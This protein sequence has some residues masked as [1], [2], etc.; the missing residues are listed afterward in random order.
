MAHCLSNKQEEFNEK[1]V[2]R[3][4][5]LLQLCNDKRRNKQ[6]SHCA[7]ARFDDTNSTRAAIS[8]RRQK[9]L[10]GLRIMASA[11]A[12][13]DNYAKQRMLQDS[14]RKTDSTI[15][16]GGMNEVCADI[17]I[18]SSNE[19]TSLQQLPPTQISPLPTSFSSLPS[20]SASHLVLL[21][22]NSCEQLTK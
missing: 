1:S 20:H 15:A 10:L 4:T 17:L 7:V 13:T 21:Y 18:A 6:D 3:S 11:S 22:V 12:V 9:L 19:W 5:C 14:E 2:E 8:S 16:G